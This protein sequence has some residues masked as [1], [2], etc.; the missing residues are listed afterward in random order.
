M[1]NAPTQRSSDASVLGPAG[2]KRDS[3]NQIIFLYL[4][5]SVSSFLNSLSFTEFSGNS[6]WAQPF[7]SFNSC[8]LKFCDTES[9]DFCPATSL[10]FPQ[11]CVLHCNAVKSPSPAFQDFQISNASAFVSSVISRAPCLQD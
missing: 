6:R 2:W 3:R 4:S 7:F 10:F 11:L 9:S 8:S 1:G 5:G